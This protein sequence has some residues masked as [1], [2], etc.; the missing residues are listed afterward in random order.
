MKLE[1]NLKTTGLEAITHKIT[2]EL[3]SFGIAEVPPLV[4]ENFVALEQ[5]TDFNDDT[6][7]ILEGVRNAQKLISSFTL[8]AIERKRLDL[9]TYL[10][11]VGKAG[12]DPDSRLAVVQ[13]FSIPNIKNREKVTV[14]EM[15]QIHF[16]DQMPT[17]TANLLKIGVTSN[18]TMLDF[19]RR[20]AGWTKDVLD[21]SPQV[22]DKNTRIIAGSHHMDSNINPYGI[23][24]KNVEEVSN[25]LKYSIFLLMAIDKYQALIVRSDL[26]HNEAMKILKNILGMY[27]GDEIMQ[28]VFRTNDQLGATDS[29]FPESKKL[30]Q[31]RKKSAIIK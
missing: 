10:H 20:H 1:N 6:K 7:T 27:D 29:L 24:L 17:M 8:N 12:A 18:S 31:K 28:F 23:D 9:A 15:T 5:H 11:D 22:F 13:L 30:Y 19:Y 25:E 16:A 26:E 2:T 21:K 3:K 14:G 4:L